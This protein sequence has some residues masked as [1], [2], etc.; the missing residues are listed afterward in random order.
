MHVS[1][2]ETIRHNIDGAVGPQHLEQPTNTMN[3]KT[4]VTR[5]LN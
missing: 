3:T 1:N 4:K 2:Y 5:G